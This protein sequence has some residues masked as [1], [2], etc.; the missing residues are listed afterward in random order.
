MIAIVD[1]G[2][3]N[4][5]S[6]EK[7]LERA[8][9]EAGA[10]VTVRVTGDR[11]AIER[12]RAV[13][14]P[15]VGAFAACMRGLR[16]AGL[17]ETAREAAREAIRGGRPFLGICV[18]MQML[19]EESLEFGSERGL[20]V[21]PGRVARLRSAGVKIPHMGWNSIRPRPGFALLDGIGE[22]AFFYFVHSY[23]AEPA[24]ESLLAA[25]TDYGG[26]T[27]AAAVGRGA[28]FGTQFHPEKSQQA[29]IALL[30]NFVRAAVA[31]AP[32]AALG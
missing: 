30:A 32:A 22:G 20:G 5:R 1:Y 24:E 9:C 27:F 8:A 28:L 23:A 6:A 11:R 19:F 29:G 21:L 18:G 16:D 10:E 13:V 4:L 15:G 7:G 14:L 2:V 3:G 12:A 17:L 26:A 25:T 31:S